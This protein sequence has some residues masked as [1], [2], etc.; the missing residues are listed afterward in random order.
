MLYFEY[1][2][3]AKIVQAE[4]TWGDWHA[5]LGARV[6]AKFE[7][8]E[9]AGSTTSSGN[10]GSSGDAASSSGTGTTT[11]NYHTRNVVLLDNGAS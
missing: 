1:R 4:V 5:V 10:S 9:P 2:Y 6:E 8:G 11:E 3:N 7:C